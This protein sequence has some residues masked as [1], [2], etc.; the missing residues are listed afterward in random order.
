VFINNNTSH[1]DVLLRVRAVHFQKITSLPRTR[2]DAG[3]RRAA[4]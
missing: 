2:V 3:S 1:D 4:S